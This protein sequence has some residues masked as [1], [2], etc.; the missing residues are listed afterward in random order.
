MSP[1]GRDCRPHWPADFRL[2]TRQSKNVFD[3]EM[4]IDVIGERIESA[5]YPD[6]VWLIGN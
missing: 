3:I 6:A 4:R 5:F 1:S 2:S